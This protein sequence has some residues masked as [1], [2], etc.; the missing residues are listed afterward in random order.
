MPSV[1]SRFERFLE[2]FQFLSRVEPEDVTKALEYSQVIMDDTSD[3]QD[4][5]LAALKLLDIITDYVPG[6]G[7]DQLVDAIHDLA[8]TEQV[9]LLV[10]SINAIWGG[11]GKMQAVGAMQQQYP[12]AIQLTDE[13]AI[14][15]DVVIQVL[16]IVLSLIN[17]FTRKPESQRRKYLEG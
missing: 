16:G 15:W 1:L 17:S 14:P 4:R 13:K 3:L 8:E 10:E 9:W 12:D 6:E 7:D 2:V 11:G 5:V